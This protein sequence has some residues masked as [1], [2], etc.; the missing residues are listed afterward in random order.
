MVLKGEIKF[1]D[2]PFGIFYAGET[3]KG[4]FELRVDEVVT[5]IK[6]IN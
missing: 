5:Q 6:S 1:D 2:K 3:I 4:K